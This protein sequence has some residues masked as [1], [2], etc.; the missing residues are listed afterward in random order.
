MEKLRS[1]IKKREIDKSMPVPEIHFDQSEQRSTYNEIIGKL[2][3]YSAQDS[4]KSV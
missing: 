3:F 2:A 1:A 4:R